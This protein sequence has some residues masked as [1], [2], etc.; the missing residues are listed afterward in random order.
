MKSLSFSLVLVSGLLLTA[1]GGPD[2]YPLAVGNRWE[3]QSSSTLTTTIYQPTESTTT[4]TGPAISSTLE[5]TGI[6]K[7]ASGEDVFVIGTTTAGVSMT[8]YARKDGSS[9]YQYVSMSDTEA[10]YTEPLDLKAGTTWS[11]TSMGVTSTSKV[12]EE[13]VTVTVPAGTYTDCLA[14]SRKTSSPGSPTVME[15][16]ANG[17]GVVKVISHQEMEQVGFMKVV[18]DVENVLTG[19]TR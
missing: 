5:I 3:M 11:S 9:L 4:T 19:F 8:L 13:G 6:E 14:I 17:V 2:F 1:C 18:T 15:Y 16:R 7:M 10:F 12:E